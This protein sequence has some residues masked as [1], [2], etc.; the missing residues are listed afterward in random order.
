M[1]VFIYMYVCMFMHI[2]IIYKCMHRFKVRNGEIKTVEH[3]HTYID[4]Y[5]DKFIHLIYVYVIYVPY[6]HAYLYTEYMYIYP[7]NI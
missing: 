6:I 7:A 5:T 3:I 1:Y 4:I 2:H